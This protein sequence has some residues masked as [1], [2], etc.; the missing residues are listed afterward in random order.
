[1]LTYLGIN[2]GKGGAG[3]GYKFLLDM[4]QWNQ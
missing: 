2:L 3:L 4:F 1:M